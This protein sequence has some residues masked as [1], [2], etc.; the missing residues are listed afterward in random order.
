[1]MYISIEHKENIETFKEWK[2]MKVLKN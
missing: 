1:V 2:R